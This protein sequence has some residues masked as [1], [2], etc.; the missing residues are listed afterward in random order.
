MNTAFGLS[1]FVSAKAIHPD[2]AEADSA[3]EHFFDHE[4]LHTMKAYKVFDTIILRN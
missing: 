4:L 1:Q 3:F 2:W